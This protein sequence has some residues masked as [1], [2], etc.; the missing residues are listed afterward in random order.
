MKVIG[1]TGGIGMGK[2]TAA[3]QLSLLGAQLCSADEIVHDLLAHAGPASDAVKQEFP[4]VVTNMGIDRKRLGD[5]VFNDK[6]RRAKLEAILHP[7]VEAEE[8]RFIEA[9]R[10]NGA[11]HVV[12]EIPLLYETGAEKRCDVVIVVTAPSFV[13][14][15]RVMVRPNMSEQK[16][17]QILAAQMPDSEKRKRADFVVQT[18]FGKAYSFWQLKRIMNKL[19]A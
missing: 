5:I 14:K 16:F 19:D 17:Q 3:A 15:S 10:S 4:E 6:T 18:G 2:S 13:Q 12:L 9:A 7:L 8:K 1:L 11:R